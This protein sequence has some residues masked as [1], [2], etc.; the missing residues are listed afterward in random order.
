MLPHSTDVLIVGA[1]PTGLALAASL[2]QAGVDHVVI[3]PL[4]ERH[5][6]SRAGVIHAHT[7]EMLE[8]I[9]VTS[10]LRLKGSPVQ[11][12]TLQVRNRSLLTIDFK[13]LASRHDYV[14]MVPQ[15]HTEAI[16]EERLQDLG[17]SVHRGFTA[18]SARRLTNGAE[19]EVEGP[20]G[21]ER[22]SARYVIGADGM[23][24]VV[25]KSAGIEFPGDAYSESFV[26]ADVMLDPPLD[27]DEV[28]LVL[29]SEGL[30]VIAPLP[31]G[32]FRIVATVEDAPEHPSIANIQ[33]LLDARG[34]DGATRV[35]DLAWSS[36]F[37]VHHRLAD[38]YRDGPFLLMGDAAHV[39]SPAGGQGMNT[40]LV[41]AV[42]LGQALVRVVRDGEA[43]TLLDDYAR[44][45]RPAALEVLGLAGRLTR[46]ATVRG[47]LTLLRN[48]ALRVL[49]RIPAFKRKLRLA[50]SGLSRRDLTILPPA[51]STRSNALPPVAPTKI[52]SLAA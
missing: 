12:F 43:E 46:V 27:R 35:T 40:G 22:I 38:A 13:G 29:A 28:S 23:H 4:T 7:L 8:A 21:N 32:S 24:S 17:G 1:G 5:H 6:L 52:D 51:A 2:Q 41:D 33:K 15:C 45:R 20:G 34:S 47:P 26:L 14:L 39:H 18:V 16:L 31:D 25:R 30:V 49:D 19:V 3:D 50:L 36:R 37:R 10:Q 42:V 9:G 11:R 44:L 48:L